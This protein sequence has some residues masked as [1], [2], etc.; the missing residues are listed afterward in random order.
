VKPFTVVLPEIEKPQKKVQIKDKMLWTTI[1]LFIYLVCCQI[2]LYGIMSNK[3]SD[4]FYWMRAILA[5]NRGTLMELG[6]TPIVTSGMVMQL[7]AGA[8]LIDVD[9]GTKEERQLF[10]SAQKLLG[11]LITIGESVAYVVSG[12]YGDV[13]E[14]GPGTAILIILQL[15][16]A[17]MLVLVLDEMLQEYGLG[18]GI[19]LFI[20]T[21]I[22]ETIIWKC[23]SPTTVNMGRGTE[24]EGAIIGLFH[25]LITKPDKVRALQEAFYRQ[26]LPNVTSLLA[27]VVVF[28]LVVYFQG[29]RVELKVK[30][31]HSP[32]PPSWRR[33]EKARGSDGT[34]PIRLFYTSNIPII[35]QTALVS[36]LYFLSQMLWKRF[37]ENVFVHLLGNWEAPEA[38]AYNQMRPIGGV[39]YY[40]SAPNSFEEVFE[41]PLHAIIY[42]AFVLTC[43]PPPPPDWKGS[44]PCSRGR[45]LTCLGRRRRT[46]R[47][48]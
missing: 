14:M 31:G 22:C 40:V 29:V 30:C 32:P 1:T 34:Y 33:H 9:Q 7:L 41:D 28:V 6:I 3:S 42:V 10:N 20:A 19:S 15:F 26:N 8:K 18:S 45:G 39:A 48:S 44:A 13:R 16:I 36:N 2:P 25:L 24:F 11:I 5:S 47:S 17:G 23:F 38:N 4:P 21:N 37:P 43:N 27:T 46:L 12:M 35:L